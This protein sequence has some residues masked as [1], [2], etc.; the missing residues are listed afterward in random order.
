MLFDSL[1]CGV[2]SC[3]TIHVFFSQKLYGHFVKFLLCTAVNETFVVW[4]GESHLLQWWTVYMHVRVR[5]CMCVWVCACSCMC[6]FKHIV[7]QKA[8]LVVCHACLPTAVARVC[9]PLRARAINV[10]PNSASL[11]YALRNL[12]LGLL[13]VLEYKSFRIQVKN[14]SPI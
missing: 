9:P 7:P 11:S 6:F 10:I 8:T 3:L 1:I 5:V 13:I 2:V 4:R 14:V 12:Y